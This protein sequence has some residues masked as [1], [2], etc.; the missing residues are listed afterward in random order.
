MKRTKKTLIMTFVLTFALLLCT[1]ITASAAVPDIK[2]SF[3]LDSNYWTYIATSTDGI[4][5][6][7]VIRVET[8][9]ADAYGNRIPVK[10]EMLPK[11][12]D[13]P[14]WSTTLN[15][16]GTPYHLYCGPDVYRVRLKPNRGT[17]YG[18]AGILAGTR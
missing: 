8:A 18:I 1:T 6:T 16:N 2:M 11:T 12:G 7:L 10:L 3:D 13:N 17:G 9:T 4:D 14:I 15:G 5:R